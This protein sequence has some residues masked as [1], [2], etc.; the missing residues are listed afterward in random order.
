MI[1]TIPTNAVPSPSLLH[2]PRRDCAVTHLSPLPGQTALR[3]HP[4]TLNERP[5]SG[6]SNSAHDDRFVGETGHHR[7]PP[8][9]SGFLNGCRKPDCRVSPRSARKT[10][11]CVSI[12]C[13]VLKGLRS[14]GPLEE[15]RGNRSRFHNRSPC[16]TVLLPVG[17]RI[18]DPA[19]DGRFVPARAVDADRYLPGERPLGD[20]A[21]EGG[22]GKPGAGQNGLHTDDAIRIIHG[23]ILSSSC[24]CT[25][26]QR[27][28]S[29]GSVPSAR[30]L[31]GSLRSIGVGDGDAGGLW[32]SVAE[33]GGNWRRTNHAMWLDQI[34][35]HRVPRTRRSAF[36]GAAIH[37]TGRLVQVDSFIAFSPVRGGL[38]AGDQPASNDPSPQGGRH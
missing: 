22:T 4:R 12:P 36:R 2:F 32:R 23:A 20:L 25:Y 31:N 26:P 10:D 9:M 24:C 17:G 11:R 6:Q 5:L 8:P 27:S 18:G 28:A 13:A 29:G 30:G 3:K 1:M 19:I 35:S 34:F 33:Q 16:G 38:L 21:I 37:A 14:G 15:W 7:V